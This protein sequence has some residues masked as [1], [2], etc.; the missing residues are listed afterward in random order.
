MEDSI[1]KSQL[2]PLFQ[3]IVENHYRLS[4]RSGVDPTLSIDA[5]KVSQKKLPGVDPAHYCAYKKPSNLKLNCFA[6]ETF[7][8]QT[9]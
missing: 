7:D 5:N 9:L 8:E 4:S 2:A 1:E 3:N 6:P